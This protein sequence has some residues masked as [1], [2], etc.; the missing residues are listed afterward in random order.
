MNF[1]ITEDP[2]KHDIIASQSI[3]KYTQVIEGTQIMLAVYQMPSMTYSAEVVLD[4]PESSSLTSV[5]VTLVHNNTEYTVFQAEYPA[6]TT[7]HPTAT[8][9]AQESG[10]YLYRVYCNDRFAYQQEVVME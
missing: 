7:R 3:A 4:L 2:D 9:V 5:R 10:D 1:I 6:N 8:L